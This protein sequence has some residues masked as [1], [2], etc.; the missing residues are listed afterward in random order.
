MDA[1]G[2]EFPL[3]MGQGGYYHPDGSGEYRSW[4]TPGDL[5][6]ISGE[7][8]FTMSRRDEFVSGHFTGEIREATYEIV[9]EWEYYPPTVSIINGIS[10]NFGIYPVEGRITPGGLNLNVQ[11]LTSDWSGGVAP[12]EYTLVYTRE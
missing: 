10:G 9:R 7:L 4:M 3:Y 5:E 6:L 12:G 1:G 11:I 8:V 2:L